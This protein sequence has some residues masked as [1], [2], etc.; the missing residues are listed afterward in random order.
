MAQSR[1]SGFHQSVACIGA[2]ALAFMAL[3]A[4]A[5]DYST[6][7]PVKLG[8]WNTNFAEAKELADAQSIPMVLFWGGAE[9]PVCKNVE[10]AVGTEVFTEW[11]AARK[12]VMVF[13]SGTSGEMHDFVRNPTGNF[14]YLCVY[15]S[16]PD[17]TA[18]TNRFSG[19]IKGALP[20][21]ATGKGIGW[22]RCR[23]RRSP[24]RFPFP[25]YA[26]PCRLR[27]RTALS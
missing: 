3:T 13:Q 25:A 16:R 21:P 5:I 1:S 11:Q 6:S 4:Q 23:A 26:R 18:T 17:G 27:R 20:W 14:P 15:W 9:C 12:L 10:A 8:E 7:L 24:L 2:A 19:T 22:R